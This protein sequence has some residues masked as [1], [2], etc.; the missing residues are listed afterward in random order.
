MG[1]GMV[2]ILLHQLPYQ[3]SGLGILSVIAWMLNVA[4]FLL[5]SAGS[6]ARYIMWPNLF[7]ETMTHPVQ[8]CYWYIICLEVANDR[9]AFSLGLST[10]VS[11]L[12]YVAV[13]VWGDP[14]LIFT[15]I[16]FWIN[17]VIALLIC[18]SI[19]LLM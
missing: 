3:F 11:M 17:A 19:L 6:I 1:T 18:L 15:E 7:L 16:V 9:A 14:M 10:I 5:L 8:A 13:P 4:I 2:S 12:C